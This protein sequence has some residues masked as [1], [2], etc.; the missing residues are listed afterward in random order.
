MCVL[1]CHRHKWKLSE[2]DTHCDRGW[3]VGVSAAGATYS[4]LRLSLAVK[5]VS[6]TPNFVLRMCFQAYKAQR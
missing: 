3:G 5:I 4:A 6:A 2:H 1:V